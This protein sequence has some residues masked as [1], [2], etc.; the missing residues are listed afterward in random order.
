MMGVLSRM[1][2]EPSNWP[3]RFH[4]AI[5]E[6]AL[7]P[8]YD[9][10]VVAVVY[11]HTQ[12]GWWMVL[13][14]TA[15][16]LTVIIASW[17]PEVSI[18]LPAA[19]LLAPIAVFAMLTV[20][21]TGEAIE[22]SFGH[23]ALKRRVPLAHVRGWRIVHCPLYYGIG[24]RLIPGGTLY[25]VRSGPAVE[26]L[27]E[28]GRVLRIGS[29]EPRRLVEAL[30]VVHQPSVPDYASVA[31]TV[32]PGGRRRLVVF[33]LLPL[34]I[35]LMFW[36]IRASEKPPRVTMSHQGMKISSGVYGVD[37]PWSIITDVSVEQTLP[38]IIRRTNGYALGGTLRGY[39]RVEGL[40]PVRLFVE[41]NQP[42]FVRISSSTQGVIYIGLG[43]GGA[44]RQLFREI[45]GSRQAM[46]R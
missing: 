30:A 38:R 27:L 33:A 15:I 42:P 40:G 13:T 16:A 5:G 4:E 10:V 14:G 28:N 34:A 26:L 44:T 19:L 46:G 41:R 21:V 9:R 43:S 22:V 1:G 39:F 29:D 36:G 25:N 20:T 8:V 31:L 7:R 37:L 35:A 32:K 23:G 6:V 2:G 12:V 11:T 18:V 17:P 3:A 45:S 24:M